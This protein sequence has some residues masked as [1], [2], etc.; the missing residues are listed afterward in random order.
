MK[1]GK[2]RKIYIT[3]Y[4]VTQNMASFQSSFVCVCVCKIQFWDEPYV[5]L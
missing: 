3:S 2:C 5:I 4:P 1:F